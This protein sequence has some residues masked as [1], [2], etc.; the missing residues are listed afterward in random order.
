MGKVYLLAIVAVLSLGSLFSGVTELS[1]SDLLEGLTDKQTRVL[2]ISRVPRLVSTLLSGMS[3]SVCGLIMQRLSQ[4]RF[5]S[6][7]TAGTLDAARLGILVSMLVFT[8][9]PPL[10]RMAVAFAFAWVGTYAFM[11]LLGRVRLRDPVFIP[12]AGMMY[13]GIIGAVSTFIAYRYDLVQNISSWLLGDFSMIL[14]GRYELLY[15]VAPC[16]VLA[17]AYA[18][19]FTIAGMGK[20]VA[21]NLGVRYGTV[22]Q[23]GLGIVAA[24]TAAVV[25]TVG[26]LPF[27]GLIVPNVVSILWG[28]DLR[29]NL[30]A[31]AM[32]GAA[33]VLACDLLGRWVIYPYEI[34][35]NVTLGVVGSLA[36]LYLIPRRA[37]H[38]G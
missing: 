27:L 6:P 15:A 14:R 13:G 4:N 19:Q 35:I 33:I 31:T 20:D 25:L 36:F 8:A 7:T 38:A 21:T 10:V 34:P 1:P 37:A 29:R 22:V 2:I 23:I 11:R 32:L 12:L 28:D 26:T 3:M 17:Y 18:N 30:P 5:V 24:T 16:L 9:A